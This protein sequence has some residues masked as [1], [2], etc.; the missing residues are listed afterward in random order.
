MRARGIHI[1]IAAKHRAPVLRTMSQFPPSPIV[2]RS[3]ALN[4]GCAAGWLDAGDAPAPGSALAPARVPA[5]ALTL[6]LDA[7]AGIAV[8]AGAVLLSCSLLF[9]FSSGAG[10]DTDAV[11]A[12]ARP[13]C[14]PQPARE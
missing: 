10:A 5:L 7:A 11:E 3:A 13:L 14:C 12:G 9:S 8:A 6:A 4:G 2:M 1:H